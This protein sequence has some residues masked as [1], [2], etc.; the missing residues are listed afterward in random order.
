[1]TEH[2]R[3]ATGQEALIATVHRIMERQEDL[4]ALV[5]TGRLPQQEPAGGMPPSAFSAEPP[6][7]AQGQGLDT[8]PA[9]LD[10]YDAAQLSEL[11]RAHRA[12]Q[13]EAAGC[14]LCA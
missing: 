10:S 4:I 5:L 11:R 12:D 14:A 7:P 3:P 2:T 8:S 1:M 13:H 9:A 6:P